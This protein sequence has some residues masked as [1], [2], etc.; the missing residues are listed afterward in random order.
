MLGYWRRTSISSRARGS[1][2]TTSSAVARS[3]AMWLASRSS[4]KSR[5]IA[6]MTALPGAWR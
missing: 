6:R 4:S 3:S 2:P 1:L 5:T